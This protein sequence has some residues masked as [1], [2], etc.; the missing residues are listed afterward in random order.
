MDRL[1]RS[2][3]KQRTKDVR[4]ILT[5]QVSFID[6]IGEQAK[7]KPAQ[8]VIKKG[9]FNVRLQGLGPKLNVIL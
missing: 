4:K 7:N 8:K 2:P 6:V 1:S 5:K 3:S 9:E